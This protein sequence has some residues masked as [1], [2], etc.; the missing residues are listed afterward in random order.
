MA[1]IAVITGSAGLI[2]SQAVE[3]FL[4]KDFQV[5]GID[6]DMRRYFFGEDGTTQWQRQR[7]QQFSNYTHYDLDIRDLS[8]LEE[9]YREFSSD[10]RLVIHTAAQ[11]SHDWAAKEPLTDFHI[12]ATGTLNLLELTRRYA[13][14]AVF[15]F[16][17]TNKVYGDTP[18]RLPLAE[19][20]TRFDLPEGH[21]FFDGIDENMSIDQSKHSLFGASKAAADVM[22]QEY[23]RYFGMLTGSFRGG[24]LT[25]PNHSGA[26]LHGFLA[27]LV[28]C[29][30]E[31]RTY[32][33]FGY[34]GKQVRDNIHSSDLVSAF[35]H[36][37][38]DPKSGEVYNIGGGR[39][40]SCS[41]LE[42]IALAEKLTGRT[43]KSEYVEQNRSGDHIWYISSLKKFQD[44]YPRWKQQYT[45][46]RTVE[47]II[48]GISERTEG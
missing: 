37:Y 33:I 41:I 2:G 21:P 25:G 48:E 4:S 13:P 8:K 38:E 17:S 47:E 30:L 34:H 19:F 46:E 11:P 10:I 32:R 29:C 42:A 3:F 26:E 27:Y 22:V 9:V 1:D 5:V 6:N 20:E 23:G 14:K 44:Q 28:K 36:F 45:L 35:W 18:N 16:C 39:K 12:N 40:N 15:I 43:F 24:C 7:L 31:G